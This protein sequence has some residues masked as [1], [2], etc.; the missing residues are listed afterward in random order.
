M[1]ISF[2]FI[3]GVLF[4]GFDSTRDW[5]QGLVFARQALYHLGHTK[6]LPPK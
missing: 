6:Y 3:L 5:T 4:F 2:A 1:T